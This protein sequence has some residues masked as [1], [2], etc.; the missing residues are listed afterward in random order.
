[1]NIFLIRKVRKF[2]KQDKIQTTKDFREDFLSHKFKEDD[3][4][5]ALIKGI[6]LKASEL[7][8]NP[9]RYKS[10]FY[11]IHKLFPRYIFIG[12]DIYKDHITLIHTSPAG[13]WEIGQYK[14]EKKL[15]KKRIIGLF[16]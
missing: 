10:K 3:V 11:A 6:H 4:K 2:V 16:L 8:P 13:N 5:N 12:Y 14:K 15:L 1:M 9:E 7:Y